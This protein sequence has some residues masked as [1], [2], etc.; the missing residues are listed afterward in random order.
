MGFEAYDPVNVEAVRSYCRSVLSEL[1]TDFGRDGN[2]VH[3]WEA[4]ALILPYGI[5][6]P[7]WLL[8]YLFDA[9]SEIG[10]IRCEVAEG[11]S[12]NREAERVG[13]ALGYG[14]GQGRGGWFKR[15]TMLE[16]DR[17][18]YFAVTE[19]LESG[20]KLDFAYDE[21]KNEVGVSRSTVARAYRRITKLK[22][23]AGD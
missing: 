8:A 1:E 21:V 22:D 2:P 4:I 13:K 17:F 14:E 18:A 10:Q 3:A 9:A 23:E 7:D 5:E 19:R 12:I 11:K 20:M 15:A 16:R 6:L